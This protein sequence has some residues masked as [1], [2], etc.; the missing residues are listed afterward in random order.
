MDESDDD[1]ESP[2]AARYAH[3]MYFPSAQG[4]A[5]PENPELSSNVTVLSCE[6]G[7]KLYL[8]GTAHFSKES[9]TEV[10][11]VGILNYGI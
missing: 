10:Q 3:M 5:R 11:Q 4:I 6:N 7:C 2:P 8:I 1:S 9:Q